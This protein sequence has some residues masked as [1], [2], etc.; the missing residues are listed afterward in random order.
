VP[1]DTAETVIV[2]AMTSPTTGYPSGAVLRRRRHRRRLPSEADD[3]GRS[4]RSRPNAA[5]VLRMVNAAR[6]LPAASR[7][8]QIQIAALQETETA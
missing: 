8:T 4:M 7:P 3:T 1:M 6:T 5:R 2:S